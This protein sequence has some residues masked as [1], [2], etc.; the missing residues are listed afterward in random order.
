MYTYGPFDQDVLDD[1]STAEALGAVKSQIVSFASGP[2]YGY[3]FSPG[4]AADS[5]RKRWDPCLA[6]H[7]SA[8]PWVLQEFGHMSAGDLELVATLVFADREAD[9][10]HRQMSRLDLR[11][12]VKVIKP[13]FADQYIDGKIEELASKALL[14]S[15]GG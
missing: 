7:A 10:E 4:R 11:R 12:R 14:A 15:T 8:I 3:E 9:R 5:M 13:R 6:N 1:L 2:G